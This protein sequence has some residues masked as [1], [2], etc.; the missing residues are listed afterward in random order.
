MDNWIKA[1]N[2]AA[3]ALEYG[4]SLAK[5][6][7]KLVDLAEKIE[8]KIRELG[9]KPAFP[10][11]LCVNQLAAHYAPLMNDD[12]IYNEGD[13]LKIDV[14][15]HVEGCVGDTAA[16]IGGNEKLIQAS[17]EA[18]NKAISLAVPGQELCIIGKAIND[19]IESHGFNSIKN[20]SG[21]HIKEYT[22]HAGI[23][24]PNYNNN[25][26]RCLEE[27]MVIAIEPFATDGSDG[28]VLESIPSN[29]Y[30]LENIKPVRNME[31]RKILK[32]IKEEFHT[33]PFAAR[34]IEKKFGKL[35]FGFRMLEREGIIRSYPQLIEKSKG[36]VAQ[37][38]HTIIVK[39]EPEIL[40]KK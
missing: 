1:G 19:T 5:P 11:T 3:E 33:L 29:I 6:G 4:L 28:M 26:T 16:T 20:L 23:S 35:G 15:A 12:T 36:M 24:I 31:A 9:G 27:G 34:W 13:M 2:I 8:G 21:H 30:L 7:I 32:C 39:K 38:E 22:L 25:D 40:T 18:L 14:G 37:S 10:T 17:R